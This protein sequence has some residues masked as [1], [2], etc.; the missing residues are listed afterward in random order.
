MPF[1]GGVLPSD[2]FGCRTWLNSESRAN[3]GVCR[4]VG[5]EKSVG[6]RLVW[7]VFFYLMAKLWRRTTYV[8]LGIT[9]HQSQKKEGKKNTTQNTRQN[10]Q[11]QQQQNGQWWW[12]FVITSSKIGHFVKKNMYNT[13]TPFCINGTLFRTFYIC[14]WFLNFFHSF[15]VIVV[16]IVD[17]R[18]FGIGT[19][20]FP[21]SLEI[22]R[23]A[24]RVFP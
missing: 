17:C 24:V 13:T 8:T 1:L 20:F 16:F 19:F 11:Q 23:C 15:F 7:G 3:V 4:Q 14:F 12:H 5:L 10:T 18:V 2:C 21:E 22:N 6:Q 9:A